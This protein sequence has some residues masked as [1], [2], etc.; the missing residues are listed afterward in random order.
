MGQV[1]FCLRRD[2]DP[3]SYGACQTKELT[4]SPPNQDD[5]LVLA[6][7]RMADTSPHVVAVIVSAQRAA[8][9][10]ASF[11]QP[12]GSAERRPI[13]E[14]VKKNI[15]GVLPKCVQQGIVSR[16]AEAY[17]TNWCA[18]TWAKVPRPS[19]YTCL[20]ARRAPQEFYGNDLVGCRL[21]WSKPRRAKHVDLSV[22]D[23]ID[24]EAGSD[25]EAANGPV[26]VDA[27]DN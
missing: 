4:G 24:S 16:D 20:E 19:L 18:G 11:Q 22:D 6:K 5:V 10:R 17:L 9:L 12:Q 13:T 3:S 25:D 15:A 2:L 1:R 23:D 27:V 7:H 8:D 14:Q 21:P 26:D